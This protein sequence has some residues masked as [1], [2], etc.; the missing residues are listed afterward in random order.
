MRS[1][2]PGCWKAEKESFEQEE[3]CKAPPRFRPFSLFSFW[4]DVGVI[5]KEPK[6]QK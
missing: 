3:L 6:K 5:N 1:T 4:A 2:T